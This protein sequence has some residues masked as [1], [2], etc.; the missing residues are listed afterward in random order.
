MSIVDV[1]AT[2]AAGFSHDAQI[3]SRGRPGFPPESLDWL[4]QDLRLG[5][6]K[7]AIELGAGTGKFTKLL[8][9]TG[10]EIVAVEPVSAM[11]AEL[12]AEQPHIRALRASAQSLPLGSAS[13]DAVVCAQSF[14]WFAT[15]ATLAEIHRVL[16]PGGMLGLV[17]NIRDKSVA[18]VNALSQIIDR[19]EGNAPRYDDGEW[20]AVFPAP[21]FDQF[22][23]RSVAHVHAGNAEQVI[24]ERTAS[25]SFVAALP[26][27]ERTRLLDQVRALI[28]ATPELGGQTTAMPYVTRMYWCQRKAAG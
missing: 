22:Q 14:H 3:Y 16:K 5:P 25:T 2:A 8:V 11:L 15:A 10:A 7:L 23:E 17:W 12:A 13:A 1:H 19:H 6:G 28:A 27:D 21:G 4:T 9:R 26:D 20:R 24:V 18:W